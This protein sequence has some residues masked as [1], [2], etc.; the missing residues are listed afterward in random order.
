MAN[1]SSTRIKGML[2]C[3]SCGRRMDF[4]KRPRHFRKVGLAG[5]LRTRHATVRQVSRY[6]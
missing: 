1:T 5:L 6:R 3:D 2:Q 4:A